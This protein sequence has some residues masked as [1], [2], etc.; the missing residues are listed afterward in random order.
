MITILISKVVLSSGN[1]M[2]SQ[3]PKVLLLRYQVEISNDRPEG[4][5]RYRNLSK[6]VI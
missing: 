4:G 3:W 2:M 1:L 5:S 6:K